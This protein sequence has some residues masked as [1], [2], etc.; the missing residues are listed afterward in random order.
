MVGDSGI[1]AMARHGATRPS[2]RTIAP[3]VAASDASGRGGRRAQPARNEQACRAAAQTA[4]APEAWFRR[5]ADQRPARAR[6]VAARA[7]PALLLLALTIGRPGPFPASTLPP[8]FDGSSA[9]AL[10]TEL[11]RDYPVA[12][13]RV[14]SGADGAAQWVQE[15]ARPLRPHGGSRTP[16]TR[17]IPGPRP[18]PAPEPR[19]RRAGLDRRRDPRSSPTVTTSASGP[20]RTTTPRARQH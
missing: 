11:A 10:A 15:Q 18:R 14:G 19:H 1:V 16:G 7:R 17:A 8:S 9:M 13:A 2:R 5:A 6:R 4:P 3:V 20:A 12:P